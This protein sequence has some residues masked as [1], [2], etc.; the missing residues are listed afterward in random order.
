MAELPH[1][2][3]LD[4][5]FDAIHP[6]GTAG[7]DARFV[8]GGGLGDAP[9]E[10]GSTAIQEAREQF[11]S[12]HSYAQFAAQVELRAGHSS[13]WG[14][15]RAALQGGFRRA[16][17]PALTTAG[18]LGVAMWV[19][20]S[21]PTEERQVSELST[22]STV[23]AKGAVTPSAAPFEH[24]KFSAPV[25]L[26][27]FV[28]A[29]EA[30]KKLEPG[31]TLGAG[32]QLRFTYDSGDFSHIVLFGLDSAGATHL[33]YPES[34]GSSLPIIPGKG[35][36]L[37]GSVELDDFA[38]EERIFAL[39][40]PEPVSTDA[41]LQRARAAWSALHRQGKGLQEMVAIPLDGPSGQATLWYR[42]VS[43]P[44]TP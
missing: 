42:K 15:L 8:A 13:R 1:D 19:W 36:P 20:P 29:G 35:L 9:G 39:F 12:R 43:G 44:W 31:T 33:Y 22:S 3:G 7:A 25:G 24:A 40:T 14:R 27:V 6:P 34:P 18:A 11:Y 37:E 26:Q 41:V 38:G 30:A 5:L 10:A 32:A 21:A 28:R 23:R 17:M 4:A 2:N 16:W